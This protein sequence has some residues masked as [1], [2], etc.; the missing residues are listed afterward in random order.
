M[1][2]K[3]QDLSDATDRGGGDPWSNALLLSHSLQPRPLAF[4]MAEVSRDKSLGET[5]RLHLKQ[6]IRSYPLSRHREAGK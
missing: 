6:S 5:L 1:A 4:Q 2:E 3:G